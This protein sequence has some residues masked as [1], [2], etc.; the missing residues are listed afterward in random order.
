MSKHKHKADKPE[1]V[2]QA[3]DVAAASADAPPAYAEW[4]VEE[5]HQ[6]ATARS[7]EGRSGLG[8]ADLVKLLEQSDK[9]GDPATTDAPAVDENKDGDVATPRTDEPV[10]GLGRDGLP[11]HD[12]TPADGARLT[13]EERADLEASGASAGVRVAT[14]KGVSVTADPLRPHPSKATPATATRADEDGVAKAYPEATPEMAPAV[15]RGIL[16]EEDETPEFRKARLQFQSN[17]DFPNCKFRFVCFADG[18]PEIVVG[19][20]GRDQAAERYGKLCG[21]EGPVTVTP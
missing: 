8:K 14:T 6:E 2:D 4:T 3:E 9:D 1:A 16:A 15:M 20:N 11:T 21:Y 5:L 17:A 10:P 7:L 18:Q 12:W 19:A 13:A